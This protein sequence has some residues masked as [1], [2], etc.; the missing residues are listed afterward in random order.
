MNREKRGTAI[1]KNVFRILIL[2]FVFI[3]FLW[4]IRT[5][6]CS[7]TYDKGILPKDPTLQNFVGLL[8]NET[9]LPSML[10]SLLVTAATI[11]ILVPV[12][13][14]ASYALGRIDFR[15]RRGLERLLLLLP[16]LPP[17]AI[18]IPLVRNMNSMH[19]YNSLAGV[20]ILNVVFLIP[21]TTYLLRNFF[22]LISKSI[23]E[24]ATIDGC[25]QVGIVARIIIPNAL[26][27][28]ASVMV[29]TFINTWLNYLYP[30]AIIAN[31]NLRT[32][33]QV[34]LAYI[35][36]YGNNYPSLTAA[37]ILTIIPPLVFFCFFQRWFIAGLF[38]TSMK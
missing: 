16:L 14:L 10:N 34:L 33:P 4:G 29:Y 13:T 21:F 22:A 27:G 36:Q 24:A 5:S 6:L 18:L 37:A 19:L 3:P 8:T 31:M 35:G 25:S 2:L 9:F 15:G 23:E 38:G 26:P 20:V 17:I 30:Y 7:S 12:V 32:L 28:I 1:V 11:V